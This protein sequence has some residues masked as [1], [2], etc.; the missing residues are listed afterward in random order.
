MKYIILFFTCITLFMLCSPAFCRPPNPSKVGALFA[1]YAVCYENELEQHS[2]F[3]EEFS[4]AFGQWLIGN[5]PGINASKF[6][7][8]LAIGLNIGAAAAT[9]EI[10]QKGKRRC[11]SIK[12]EFNRLCNTIG[13]RP[14][15]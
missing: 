15:L 3:G 9:M 2:D 4:E 14:P 13:V 11:S 7:Q 5:N 8:E 1:Y 10:K 12:K 6:M